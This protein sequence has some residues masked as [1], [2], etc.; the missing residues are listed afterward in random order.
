V[1]QATEA[2]RDAGGV[3]GCL[4]IETTPDQI[5]ECVYDSGQFDLVGER[6]TTYCDP[7]LNPGQALLVVSEWA[8]CAVSRRHQ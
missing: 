3:V 6:Y 5:T 2:I 8:R 7:R 4:H 1:W